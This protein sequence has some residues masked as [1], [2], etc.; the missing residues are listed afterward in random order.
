MWRS[1]RQRGQTPGGRGR[2]RAS[3]GRTS[4]GR[5]PPSTAPRPAASARAS[6][7][8]GKHT[9]SRSLG[10]THARVR[11]EKK[12]G[13][14]MIRAKKTRKEH[15]AERMGQKTKRTK[16]RGKQKRQFTQVH[17]ANDTQNPAGISTHIQGRAYKVE[18]EEEAG[19]RC[20][21]IERACAPHS[22][23]RKA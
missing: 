22:V 15:G 4:P 1:R 19:T 21:E 23:S 17:K 13:K 11:R 10:D 3:S 6:G 7:S 16:R 20:R 2:R 5:S 12:M 9:P 8:C 18:G 14:K